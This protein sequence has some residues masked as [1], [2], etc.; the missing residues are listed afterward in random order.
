MFEAQAG[1]D[2]IVAFR[3]RAALD[4]DDLRPRRSGR[5]SRLQRCR[6]RVRR[7]GLTG[8]DAFAVSAEIADQQDPVPRRLPR[9]ARV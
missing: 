9:G 1:F 5:P 4:A 6:E 7:A 3:G 2:R 8:R